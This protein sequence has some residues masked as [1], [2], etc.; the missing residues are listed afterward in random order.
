MMLKRRTEDAK[1]DWRHDTRQDYVPET[2]FGAP[3]PMTE[4]SRDPEWNPIT[5]RPSH[6]LSDND[7]QPGVE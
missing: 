5:Y 1:S 3:D 6:N 4:A 2:I 7:S